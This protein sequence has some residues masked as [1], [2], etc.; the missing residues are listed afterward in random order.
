[1]SHARTRGRQFL[2]LGRQ[3]RAPA[4]GQ[5][6]LDPVLGRGQ[7]QFLQPGDRAGRERGV[8]H[9]HQRRAAPQVQRSAQPRG[10]GF[11]VSGGQGRAARSN[12]VASTSPGSTA[13][14]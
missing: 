12:W 5:V 3:F 13:S 11:R 7:P 9:V 4:E 1:L 14:R 8:I 2:S 10:G 6:R